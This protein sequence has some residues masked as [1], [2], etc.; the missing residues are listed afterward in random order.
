MK[1]FKKLEGILGSKEELTEMASALARRLQSVDMEGI[2]KLDAVGD[3]EI[4]EKTVG[5][6][7]A[8]D[9]AIT[10]WATTMD[11]GVA[12]EKSY[13]MNLEAL[14]SGNS[15]LL[16]PYHKLLNVGVVCAQLAWRLNRL[17]AADEY[18]ADPQNQ[19]LLDALETSEKKIGGLDAFLDFGESLIEAAA[20]LFYA[21][22]AEEPADAP[23]EAPAET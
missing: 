5:L 20:V 22:K 15:T 2:D 3:W 8:V 1:T 11:T 21:L 12:Y 13:M 10:I 14:A 9:A 4:Y 6:L 18:V 19:H 7:Y 17:A 16:V 23:E